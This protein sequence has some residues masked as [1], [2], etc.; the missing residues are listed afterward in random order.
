MI[1]SA[2]QRA[3]HL[4]LVAKRSLIW[5]NLTAEFTQQQDAAT[6]KQNRGGIV[7]SSIVVV[8]SVFE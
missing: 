6:E 7:S 5:I 1:A 3:S 2:Y 4:I 8:L